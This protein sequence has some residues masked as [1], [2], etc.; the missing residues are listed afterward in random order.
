MANRADEIFDE[1]TQICEQYK[2]EVPSDRGP[3]PESVK[4]RVFELKALGMSFVKI[5]E[6]TGIPYGSI[7]SWKRPASFL[8]VAVVDKPSPTVTVRKPRK[9]RE[10]AEFRTVTVITPSGYRIEGLDVATIT[11]FICRVESYESEI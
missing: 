5:A 2:T 8:P 10:K 1:L 7:T 6:R 4:A 11:E 9:K 3:W